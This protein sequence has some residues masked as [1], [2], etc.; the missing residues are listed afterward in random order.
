MALITRSLA[1][2]EET[3]DYIETEKPTARASRANLRAYL[4]T[5]PDYAASD[6]RGVKLNG[7]AKG[8][9]AQQGGLRAGDI[10]VEIAGRGI[11]NI[12]D[13]TYALNALK[14]GQETEILVLRDGREKKLAVLPAPRE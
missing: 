6:I 1:Q 11:E 8:G 13:L 14:V 10:I 2:R 3:P 4:G 7:V 12:Y 5:I 9:P